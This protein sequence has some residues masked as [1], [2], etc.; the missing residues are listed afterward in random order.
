MLIVYIV[1][2][3]VVLFFILSMMGPREYSVVRS[4]SVARN[5]A[6]VY[7]YLKYLK[8]HDDWSPWARRDPNMAKTYKGTDAE[9]GF[10]SH[11]SGNKDV[12]EGEQEISRLVENE[13]MEMHLRFLKPWK[14]EAEV[15][16]QLDDSTGETSVTWGMQGENKTAVQRVMGLFMNMDK[17]LGKDF[18]EGLSNL[19]TKLE[20]D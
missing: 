4:V 3:V 13:R 8:N 5:K 12:G 1:L 19:K 6:E 7:D 14:T 15:Y 18:D 10:V 9:T 2:G 16:L 20:A 17:M 11:W